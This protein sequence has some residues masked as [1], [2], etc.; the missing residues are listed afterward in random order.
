[1]GVGLMGALRGTRVLSAIALFAATT[2]GLTACVAAPE[3]H[4]AT[5]T[6][7]E[8]SAPPEEDDDDFGRGDLIPDEPELSPPTM[9]TV[10]MVD[11]VAQS[12]SIEAPAGWDTTLYSTGMFSDHRQVVLSV[13]PDGR[14]VLFTGEPYSPDYWVPNAPG[15]QTDAVR[16]WVAQGSL[17]QWRE[18]THATTWLEEWALGK[19]GGLEG[20]VLLGTMDDPDTAAEVSN[21]FAQQGMQVT[22]TAA[23][24]TFLYDTAEGISSGL[25]E[26]VT[27]GTDQTWGIVVKG[28]STLGDPADYEPM[29]D[30]MSASQQTSPEWQSRQNQF[31]Q[32]MQ[33]QSEAFTRQLIDNHNAN[34]AWIRNSAAAHQSRMQS[35]WAANDASM[36]SF[37]S[38]MESMDNNQRSFLN[39]IQ[40]EHTVQN[41]AGQTF[42][43]VQGPEVYYV[44]P[45]TGQSLGGNAA[46]SEQDLI[47]M[48]LNPS[49]WTLTQII[50]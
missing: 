21:A 4:T 16:N 3:E 2:I 42:Q 22:V 36:N 35:I 17:A 5:P 18:Y 6:T 29:L 49:D 40:G 44:N 25:A 45:G 46:F 31:W 19:F 10:T 39:Y 24:T 37:Y 28:L 50:R 14:T 34:M 7:Q 13:S 38:R 33:A 43:V 23:R 1:M 26:A 41:S 32:Q 48:G 30:A 12:F 8:V 47:A 9:E 20:F 27:Y 11:P 15:N